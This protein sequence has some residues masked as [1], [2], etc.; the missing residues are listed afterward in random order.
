MAERQFPTVQVLPIIFPL[1]ISSKTIGGDKT[2]NKPWTLY[3]A[4]QRAS[5]SVAEESLL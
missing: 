1:S 4:A 2:I 3:R 5:W